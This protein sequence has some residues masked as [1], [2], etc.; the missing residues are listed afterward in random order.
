MIIAAEETRRHAAVKKPIAA[1]IT[2]ACLMAAA[3]MPGRAEEKARP[4]PLTTAEVLA[5]AKAEDWRALDP[6]NT[7]YLELESGRVVIELAP[8]F[9]PNHTA[10]VKV[11]ARERYFDGLAILRV[12]DNYVVQWGDP[13]AD[14]PAKSRKI[15]R[16]RKTLP[17]EFDRPCGDGVPFTPLP[18][19]DVYAPEAGFVNGFPAARDRKNGRM[20]LV[21]CYGMVGA[22]RGDT[23]DSGGGAEIYVAIGH[24]PRHLDRNCTLF[25]RVV[26]GM[27][28]LSSLPRASGAMGFI[29]EA[30]DLIPIRSVRVA[31]DVPP[32]ERS[33]LE[34]LRTDTETFRNLIQARRDRSEDWFLSKPG[35]VEICNVPLPARQ[36]PRGG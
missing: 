25:G 20:W 4:K 23:A 19:G 34:V 27:E 6:E 2:L 30:E 18:D 32:A 5:M 33:D 26:Q 22:G 7:L 29:E 9:A 21:H 31:A 28:R 3:G 13:S 24:S 8:L 17:A 36:R 14:D 10:N 16:A 11:L 35:R 15:L 12:Q 1:C